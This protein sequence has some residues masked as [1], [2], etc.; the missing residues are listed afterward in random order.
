MPVSSGVLADQLQVT[1]RK[2]MR[3]NPSGNCVEVAALPDGA[4]AVRACAGLHPRGN[5]GVPGRGTEWRVR[6][7]GLRSAAGERLAECGRPAPGSQV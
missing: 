3:S 6:R 4:V 7:S 1:W 5:R 2:S